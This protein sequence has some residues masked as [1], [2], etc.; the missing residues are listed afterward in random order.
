MNSRLV[1]IDL[2]K[3]APAMS[4]NPSPNSTVPINSS[5]DESRDERIHRAQSSSNAFDQENVV[6][7]IVRQKD[8]G[9]KTKY[10]V[11]R[12]GNTPTDDTVELPENIPQQCVTRY[13]QHV[14]KQNQNW[15]PTHSTQH[16]HTTTYNAFI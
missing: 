7:R 16:E 2:V 8:S 1:S 11:G 14:K 12:Y 3:I 6:D 5:N 4:R 13:L 10:N 9:K 15:E